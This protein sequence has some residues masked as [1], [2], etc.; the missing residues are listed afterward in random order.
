[1]GLVVHGIGE[2]PAGQ[3]LRQVAGQFLPLIR[4]RIDPYAGISATPL[5]GQGSAEV[6]IWFDVPAASEATGSETSM[7]PARWEIRFLEVWWARSFGPPTPADMLAGTMQFARTLASGV[8]AACLAGRRQRQLTR[9]LAER[10]QCAV[11]KERF[12]RRRRDLEQALASPRIDLRRLWPRRE[13]WGPAVFQR[14]VVDITVLTAAAGLLPLLLV[15][16]AL[17]AVRAPSLLPPV[18]ARGYDVVTAALTRHLGDLWVY[19]RQPWE[20]SQIRCRFEDRFIDLLDRVQCEAA[21]AVFVIAHSLGAVI[22]FEALTG[23]RMTHR[24]RQA[25]A[26]PGGPCAHFISVG[27]ALNTVWQIAPAEERFRFC[28]RLPPLVRWLDL[29]ATADPVSRGPL[30]PPASLIPLPI[31]SR[32]VVN[33]MDAFS[34]HVA[35]WSNAEEVVA[36]ILDRITG[37]SLRHLLEMDIAGRRRRVEALALAKA[38]AWLAGPA[39]FLAGA[40]IGA[41]GWSETSAPQVLRASG[42]KPLLALSAAWAVVA[43]VLAVCVYST[44]VRW[45][46]GWWDRRARYRRPGY[47]GGRTLGSAGTAPSADTFVPA[48]RHKGGRP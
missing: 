2:Q 17:R 9:L 46:W 28:R 43:A 29:W 25:V 34:D 40:I 44:V 48:R 6:R 41:G 21:E 3:V 45:L 16:S 26:R 30:R 24:L 39:V 7:A 13:S 20:A 35:Y 19:L 10:A 42:W 12:A 36:P 22:A 4:A 8:L 18:V 5:D 37:G 31:D 47:D 15:L 14:L 32:P 38:M 11:S 27:S 33:Q 23:R 1:M